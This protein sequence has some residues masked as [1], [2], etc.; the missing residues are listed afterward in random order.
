MSVVFVLSN[1]TPSTLEK[2]GLLASTEIFALQ[3]TK[4][5]IPIFDIK[6]EMDTVANVLQNENAISPIEVAVAGS[7]IEVSTEY[8]IPGSS[9]GI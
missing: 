9:L 8:P 5:R 2:Y 3:P 4:A 6:G 7:L 1:N